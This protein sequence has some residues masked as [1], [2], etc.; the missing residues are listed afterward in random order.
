MK[1]FNSLIKQIKNLWEKWTLIQKII[2]FAIVAAMVIGCVAFL[3]V[4]T[5]LKWVPV[6]SYPIRDELALERIVVR[7]NKEGYLS[8]INANG[9]VM[10]E[11]KDI[12]RKMRAILIREDLV[13]T[14]V[15]PWIILNEESETTSDYEQDIFYL[16]IKFQRAL[17]MMIKDHIKAMDG[18]NNAYVNIVFSDNRFPLDQMDQN[19]VSASVIIIPASGSDISRNRKNIEDIQK[20]LKFA[21]E[22]LEDENIVI[23]D[24]N[25]IWLNDFEG[26]NDIDE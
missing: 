26:L 20:M 14:S 10:V 11:N 18:V 22:G 24:Q 5:S 1:I 4:S 7:I 15:D 3:S 8:A 19:P 25:G 2:L 6:F 9:I 21:V 12:A 13:P 16:R 17:S 23:T